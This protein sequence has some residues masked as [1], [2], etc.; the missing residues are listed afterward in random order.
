MRLYQ[1][2]QRLNS[3]LGNGT[4]AASATKRLVFKGIVSVVTKQACEIEFS[5]RT[6]FLGTLRRS[7][8]TREIRWSNEGRVAMFVREQRGRGT[9]EDTFLNNESHTVWAASRGSVWSGR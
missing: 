5:A 7:L 9:A 3:T 1:S 6:R 8:Q 4:K 2:V